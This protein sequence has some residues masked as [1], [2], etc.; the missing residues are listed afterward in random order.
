MIDEMQMTKSIELT[1]KMTDF[2][3][4][5]IVEM[6]VWLEKKFRAEDREN[7]AYRA[8][9]CALRMEARRLKT[10]SEWMFAA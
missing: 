6:Y 1:E 8:R 4:D 9:M 3:Y 5:Y 2:E 10:R 7:L